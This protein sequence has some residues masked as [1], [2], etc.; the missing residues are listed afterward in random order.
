MSS[1]L[2]SRYRLRSKSKRLDS[3]FVASNGCSFDV[4]FSVENTKITQFYFVDKNWDDAKCKSIKI[5]PLAHVLVDNKTGKLKFDA[6]QPNIFSIDMGVKE[7]K[8]KISS[9]IPQ[10]NQLIQA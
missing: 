6:I 2:L 5:K 9:F 10:V 8:A 7:L 1:H 3:D 4:Y